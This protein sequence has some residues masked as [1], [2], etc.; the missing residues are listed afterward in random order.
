MKSKLEFYIFQL[1]FSVPSLIVS[2]PIK[3]ESL[4]ECMCG[5]RASYYIFGM[6]LIGVIISIIGFVKLRNRGFPI[7]LF[8]TLIICCALILWPPD[9]PYLPTIEELHSVDGLS[10][11]PLGTL[12]QR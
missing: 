6:P 2:W 8:V 7:I 10:E 11:V 1:L 4:F 5:H 3:V 12:Q 9:M